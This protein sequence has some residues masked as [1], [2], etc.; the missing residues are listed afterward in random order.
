[1][2]RVNH[3]L[4]QFSCFNLR[5]CVVL[6]LLFLSGIVNAQ[7][8]FFQ[9]GKQE[10][11]FSVNAVKLPAPLKVW[12]YSPHDR[13]DTLPIVI[14][15]H[16]AERNPSNYLNQWM[17][18]A[19]LYNFVVIAPEFD[20]TQYKGSERYNLGNVW[21]EKSASFNSADQWSFSAIEPLFDYLKTNLHSSRST[22][23]LSGHSAG[24]QFVHRFLYFVPT[25]RAEKVMIANAGWYTLPDLSSTY[26]FGVSNIPFANKAISSFFGKPVY[27]VLG[28][29]DVDTTSAN[30]QK[31]LPYSLQGATRYERGRFFYDYCKQ[32]AARLNLPFN[33]HLF[34][35]PGVAHSN[36]ETAKLAGA[37]F[38]SKLI[39]K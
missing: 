5:I 29:Q 37:I 35:M 12:Y 19:D 30:F 24:A 22:Y 34:T 33:W 2:Q 26:P 8:N 3:S 7:F 13:P 1:M 32:N 39:D 4:F 10:F 28:E 18:V 17:P 16:G 36:A 6:L 27:M 25:N 14:M 20:R 9:K 21:D 11:L 31:G 23:F 38:R 15:L